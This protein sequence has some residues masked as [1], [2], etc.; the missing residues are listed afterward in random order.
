MW[1]ERFESII[2]DRL[3]HL[4]PDLALEPDLVLA[5]HGLD[6]MGTLGLI[7]ALEDE[8]ALTLPDEAVTPANFVTPRTVFEMLRAL[9][10]AAGG[11]PAGGETP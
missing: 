8:Y 2:R 6:S 4:R 10:P 5:A 3:P 11:E 9:V 1:D 7:A